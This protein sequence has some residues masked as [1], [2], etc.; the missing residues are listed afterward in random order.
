MPGYVYF[1]TNQKNG[2]LYHGVTSHLAQRID[3][4]RNGILPGFTK[5]YNLTRLVAI[6][7]FDHIAEAIQREKQLKNWKRAWKIALIE[8]QNP[9]WNDLYE[10][11]NG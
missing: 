8:E 9:E 6:E 4:H 10:T 5:R 2:T 7:T 1:M 3:Q 11:L